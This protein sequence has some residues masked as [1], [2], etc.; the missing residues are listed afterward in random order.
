MDFC[1]TLEGFYDNWNQAASNPTK[2]SHCYI[3][4]ERIGDNELTSKQWYHHE[5][6]DKPYRYRWHRVI[7]FG[8]TTI[9]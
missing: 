6:E 2:Y 9:D 8:D 3:R 5:G 4:W 7:P 1:D